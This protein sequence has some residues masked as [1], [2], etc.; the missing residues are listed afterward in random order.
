[1]V[2]NDVNIMALGEHF[3]AWPEY[4]QLLF[5]KAATGIGC[6]IIADGQVY[7][8]AQG[9]AG[10]MGHIRVAGADDVLCRCGNT[11]CLEAIASGAAIA[12][13]LGGEGIP[14]ER[15]ARRGRTGPRRLRPRP[16]PR[17]PGR[18]GHRRGP[19]RRP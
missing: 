15:L 14:A 10:D 17:P 18:Q 8:G 11:G 2:D 4:E 12:A 13:Q 6:G 3:T 7:R 5:V 9:A 16:A 19:R 1:M